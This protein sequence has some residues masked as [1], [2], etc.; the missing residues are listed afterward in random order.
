M[1]FAVLLLIFDNYL[2]GQII[3]SISRKVSRKLFDRITNIIELTLLINGVKFR[4]DGGRIEKQ[5]NRNNNTT[6][7]KGRR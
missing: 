3:Y 6:P 1:F 7:G 4:I 5:K 2:F